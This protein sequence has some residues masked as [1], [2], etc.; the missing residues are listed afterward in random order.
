MGI[1]SES[2]FAKLSIDEQIAEYKRLERLMA[3]AHSEQNNI[4]NQCQHLRLTKKHLVY[5]RW[6]D[7]WQD[8]N[9]AHKAGED[10]DSHVWC[11]VCGKDF[12]WYCPVNPKG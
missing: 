10:E 11:T 9:L 3:T 4:R 5:D 1:R 7:Q 8:N 6:Y 12:G 2:D